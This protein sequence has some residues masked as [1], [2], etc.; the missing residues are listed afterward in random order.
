MLRAFRLVQRKSG[1]V[2]LKVVRGADFDAQRFAD[3][4]RRIERCL[5]G[6]TVRVVFCDKIA[7]S[8]GGKR[9]PIVV[10]T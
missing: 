2:E 8:A 4:V 6:R 10:E 7:A 3:V 5:G 9:R 1:D